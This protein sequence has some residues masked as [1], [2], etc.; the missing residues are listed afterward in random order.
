VATPVT[1]A[2]F[3][4]GPAGARAARARGRRERRERGAGAAGRPFAEPGRDRPL[5]GIE[6]SSESTDLGA[7]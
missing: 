5:G 4:D 6:L 2:A 3:R 1:V 7:E